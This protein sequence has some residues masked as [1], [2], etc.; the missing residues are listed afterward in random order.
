MGEGSTVAA[1][2]ASQDAAPVISD[3]SQ[4]K[5]EQIIRINNIAVQLPGFCKLA[6]VRR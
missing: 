6:R 5:S 3:A 4:A 1:P 2:A